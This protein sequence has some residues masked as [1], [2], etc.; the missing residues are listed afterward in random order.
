MSEKES[1]IKEFVKSIM[2]YELKHLLKDEMYI[3]AKNLF[4]EKSKKVFVSQEIK[5]MLYEFAE[6]K[7]MEIEK[8]EK[9]FKEVLPKG[10]ENSLKVLVYNK[11]PE[12]MSSAKEFIKDEKFKDKIKLEINKFISG[13]NPMVSKFINAESI[14]NK[15]F[16]SLSSYFDDP[17]NM[18]SIVM[19]INN[20]IDESS[21]KSVSEITNYI[22]YEGKIVFIRGLI[23]ILIGSFVE[24]TFIKKIVDNLE[25]EVVKKGTLGELVRDLGINEEKIFQRL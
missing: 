5:S 3:E 25:N 6:A 15:I 14:N 7:I 17:E 2:N 11:G 21:N 24:E 16:T 13:V 8:E 18:M 19:I 12:I 9:S 10:F 22:P 20:K 4:I 23:D 1:I